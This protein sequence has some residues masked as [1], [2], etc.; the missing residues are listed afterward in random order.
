MLLLGIDTSTFF[1]SIALTDSDKVIAEHNVNLK[2]THSERLLPGIKNLLQETGFTL[3]QIN[4]IA[5]TIGPGSFTGLRIGLSTAKALAAATGKPLIGVS[6]LD[7]LAAGV[8]AGEGLICAVLDARRGELYTALYRNNPAGQLVRESE[9]LN[10]PPKKILKL[11]QEPVLFVGDG[12]IAYGD[13][14]QQSSLQKAT[15]APMEYNYPRAS[16]LCRLAVKKFSEK[17]TILPGDLQA[18][19]IRPSDA[20]LSRQRPGSKV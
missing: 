4:A 8:F 19:Y 2:T 13:L 18:L 1:G 20:E 15:F 7:V 3:K 17:K 14:L 11:I 9:Y 10:L 6:T 5:I 12:L 16:T